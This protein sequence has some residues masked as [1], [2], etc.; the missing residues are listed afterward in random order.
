MTDLIIDTLGALIVAVVGYTFLKKD[1]KKF[2]KSIKEG[3]E[4]KQKEE[5]L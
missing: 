1:K 5:N 3:F 4:G 2:F